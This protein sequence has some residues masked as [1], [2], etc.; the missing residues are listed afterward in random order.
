MTDNRVHHRSNKQHFASAYNIKC[1]ICTFCLVLYT[2]NSCFPLYAQ[3]LPPAKGSYLAFGTSK[4]MQEFGN[5][6]ECWIC[7]EFVVRTLGK[8]QGFGSVPLH[9]LRS[10]Q[11]GRWTGLNSRVS[12]NTVSFEVREGLMFHP[13]SFGH[14][15]SC[16]HPHVCISGPL[17]LWQ[18]FSHPLIICLHTKRVI[19]SLICLGLEVL[20]WHDDVS[21]WNAPI[22]RTFRR[23]VEQAS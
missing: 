16:L 14:V 13:Y 7:T 22:W 17:Q 5:K 8:W 9:Y 2:I 12:N 10:I 3:M 18:C 15:S 19:Y 6:T 23:G 20:S 1:Q 21:R 11:G 4:H